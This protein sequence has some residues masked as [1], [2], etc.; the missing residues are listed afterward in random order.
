MPPHLVQ[1]AITSVVS[2]LV[3]GAVAWRMLGRGHRGY[4]RK[5]AQELTDSVHDR[6]S[7]YRKLENR[8]DSAIADFERRDAELRNDLT[9][10]SFDA[11]GEATIESTDVPT[12]AATVEPF[13]ES[14]GAGGGE[15]VVAEGAAEGT[16]G[17]SDA[18]S[19]MDACDGPGG[20]VQEDAGRTA[21]VG[22]PVA[23]P[24]KAAFVGLQLPEERPV[25]ETANVVDQIT[26]GLE[27]MQREKTAEL[28]NQRARIDEHHGRLDQ[29]H[30]RI[31]G[32]EGRQRELEASLR[33]MQQDASLARTPER[34]PA[35]HVEDWTR[36]LRE[37]HERLVRSERELAAWRAEHERW[38]RER[39]LCIES[40]RDLASRIAEHGLRNP[41]AEAAATSVRARAEELARETAQ[42]QAA[43][44]RRDLG[45]PRPIPPATPAPAE[46]A[47]R[48]AAA[49]PSRSA[50]TETPA[51]LSPAAPAPT[52]ARA[53]PA[54]P[55]AVETPPAIR[56]AAPAKPA[57]EVVGFRRQ[58]PAPSQPARPLPAF[59]DIASLVDAMPGP[60]PAAAD[61][62]PGSSSQISQLMRNL[63]I[64][65][66]EAEKYRKKL[67]EQSTQFTAAYAMLDRIRPFVQALESEYAAQAG[68]RPE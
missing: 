54:R 42:L 49:I 34:A 15:P 65:Q 23:E 37:I 25:E 66:G 59:E 60:F 2:F 45:A 53:E 28:A 18:L 68:P 43:I 3:G 57:A 6:C 50:P 31:E 14:T 7:A 67:H 33:G 48:P 38:S 41:E 64:A 21:F 58:D 13:V 8:I 27:V 20:G 56:P 17:E 16:M 51:T 22:L 63:E 36:S 9:G 39:M 32:L 47:P 10:M 35:A 62:A 11:P 26:R 1:V 29:H 30:G 12:D 44:A 5:L 52:P 19:W 46:T 24:A 61:P 55:Q 4:S 40:A